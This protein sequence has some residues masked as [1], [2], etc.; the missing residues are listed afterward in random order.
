MKDWPWDSIL[1]TSKNFDA[2]EGLILCY[3]QQPVCLKITECIEGSEWDI[4]W[5]D[6]VHDTPTIN[7]SNPNPSKDSIQNALVCANKG[8]WTVKWGDMD[9]LKPQ[10]LQSTFIVNNPVNWL[11]TQWRMMMIK[12]KSWWTIDAW[13]TT[14]TVTDKIYAMSEN[15]RKWDHSAK[16]HK[17]Y[18]KKVDQRFRKP[19]KCE[20]GVHKKPIVAGGNMERAQWVVW[21]Y[22][23]TKSRKSQCLPLRF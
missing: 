5:R 20:S 8:H 15:Y 19:R 7:V 23:P 6:V 21:Q 2:L 4:I 11:C 12:H 14:W 18:A 10:P 22:H 16:R 17:Y 1:L 13:P 9:L 3:T